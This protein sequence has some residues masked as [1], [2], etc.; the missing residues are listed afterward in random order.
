MNH[1]PKLKNGVLNLKGQRFGHLVVTYSTGKKSKGKRIWLC[2]C[3]CGRSLEVRHDYLINKNSPKTHCGCKAVKG[4]L[5]SQFPEEYHVHNSMLRRCYNETHAGYSD[6]GG[7]GIRVCDRWRESFANFLEDVGPRPSKKHSLDRINPDGNY[8][9]TNVR[10][11]TLQEQAR[12]KRKS[13][14]LPHPETGKM[15]PA[16][17]V[18]EYLG[19]SYHAMR[20]RYI[21]EGKWPR[22]PKQEHTKDQT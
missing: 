13:L 15:I 4:G 14:F 1:L 2:R 9:P 18:A 11:A 5:P 17:A 7:R 12:N 16:A 21:K 3:D 22:S 19:I 10:W 8:E 6:Y 20:T